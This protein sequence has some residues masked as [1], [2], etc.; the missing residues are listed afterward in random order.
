M[1]GETVLANLA[2]RGVGRLTS[3]EVME[4]LGRTLG[5]G[6]VAKLLGVCHGRVQQAEQNALRKLRR[7]LAELEQDYG[8]ES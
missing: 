2:G 6:E 8:G 3:D 5:V 1:D 4:L 7:R